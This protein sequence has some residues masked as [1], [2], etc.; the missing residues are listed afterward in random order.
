MHT[1]SLRSFQEM[2]GRW[3]HVLRT[4]QKGNRR[5]SPFARLFIKNQ[6]VK[7]HNFD[8]DLKARN[9]TQTYN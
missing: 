2:N 8:F 6:G 5:F 9:Y 1:G 4:R 3:G 7:P